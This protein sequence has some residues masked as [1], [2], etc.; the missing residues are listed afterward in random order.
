MEGEEIKPIPHQS[1]S[2]PSSAGSG[3][4]LHHRSRPLSSPDTSSGSLESVGEEDAFIRQ[5]TV[6]N[7]TRR[8]PGFLRNIRMPKAMRFASPERG[9]EDGDRE[10]QRRR[11]NVRSLQI[12]AGIVGLFGVLW[13]FVL[14]KFIKHDYFTKFEDY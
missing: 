4:V 13:F 2:P 14:L 7:V 5:K 8:I 1:P 3:S 6:R 12:Q 9:D 11:R 10:A